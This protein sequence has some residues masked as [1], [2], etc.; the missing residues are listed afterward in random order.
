MIEQAVSAEAL[1]L[2]LECA[3]GDA[4]LAADLSQ[5]GATDQ[6]MEQG[7]EQVRIP[8]PVAGGEGLRTE[9]PVAMMTLV[10]LHG[11]R[12]MGSLVEALLLEAPRG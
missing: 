1:G 9:V 8:Q 3:V 10:P 12:S 11:E 2:A 4:E 5:T 7:S 6:A